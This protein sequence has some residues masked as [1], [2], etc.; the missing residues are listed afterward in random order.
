MKFNTI[1]LWCLVGL[2]FFN[3]GDSA[4]AIAVW[5]T[6]SFVQLQAWLAKGY[7]LVDAVEGTGVFARGIE[8]EP[9]FYLID[10]HNGYLIGSY[11][12]VK[13][14]PPEQAVNDAEKLAK[15]GHSCVLARGGQFFDGEKVRVRRL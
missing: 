15:T 9:V 7:S 14:A 12:G 6:V 8:V 5:I 11:K 2:V 3:H 4:V 13:D 10:L 1:V